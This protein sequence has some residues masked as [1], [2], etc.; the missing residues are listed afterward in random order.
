W[1]GGPHAV[2]L[3]WCWFLN[4]NSPFFFFTI[5][6]KFTYHQLKEKVF[7]EFISLKETMF[8]LRL[9]KD[10]NFFVTSGKVTSK[11]VNYSEEKK[12]GWHLHL[13]ISADIHFVL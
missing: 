9:L 12:K 1:E 2:Y 8:T 3:L 7:L 4:P 5:A 10:T 13:K 11:H 6:Q